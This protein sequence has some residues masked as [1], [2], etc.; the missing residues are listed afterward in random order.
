M[1]NV[2]HIAPEVEYIMLNQVCETE[3]VIGEKNEST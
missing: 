3:N 1:I 2:L